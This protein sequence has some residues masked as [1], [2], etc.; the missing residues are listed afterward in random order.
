MLV[1]RLCAAT[2]SIFLILG[3][4]TTNGIADDAGDLSA[5]IRG[6]FLKQ[7]VSG[8][9]QKI[10]REIQGIYEQFDYAALWQSRGSGEKRHNLLK[11][12]LSSAGDHGLPQTEI[13]LLRTIGLEDFLTPERADILF[14]T[15]L[16]V[17][18]DD[19]RHGATPHAAM[20]SKWTL[21]PDPMDIGGALVTALKND[22]LAEF[23]ASLAPSH[24]QYKAL[25]EALKRYRLIEQNGGWPPIPGLEEIRTDTADER[26]EIL[27]KR[28]I[29]EG[30]LDSRERHDPIAV[31][32]AVREFQRR[33]GLIADGRVG[34]RTLSVLNVSVTDRIGQ[35]AANME[36]WRH[37]PRDL[38]DMHIA[39]NVADAEIALT[40]KSKVTLRMR[41]V[42]GDKDHATPVMA[43]HITGVTFNPSWTIPASIAVKEILPKL[44]RNP[45]YLADNEIEILDGAPDDPHGL[46]IVWGRISPRA[47]PYVLRQRPGSKNPLGAVKFEMEN[48]ASIFL[49]DTSAPALF[50]RLDRALSHGCVRVERPEELACRLL[51]QLSQEG[52]TEAVEKLIAE[53]TTRTLALPQPMPVYLLYWTAF[54]DERGRLNFREDIYGLDAQIRNAPGKYSAQQ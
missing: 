39:V 1:P 3:F 25:I 36:R 44:R 15:L 5:Q 32:S 40:E 13:D 50:A 52:S 14:T 30:D 12:A 41:A 48:P 4:G 29:T 16:Y 18:A 21:N 23:L 26:V 37:V 54:V 8:R 6:T 20:G 24:P 46:Q 22:R 34:K 2:F 38:G 33:N 42:V 49:H 19:L 45:R 53:K 47:F 11:Q 43:A 28:L 31:A 17:Y 35:I 9:Y 51:P 27:V 7:P 10:V